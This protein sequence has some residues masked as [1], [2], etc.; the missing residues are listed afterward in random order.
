MEITSTTNELEDVIEGVKLRLV[1][2]SEKPV[3]ITIRGDTEKALENA[4]KFTEEFNKFAALVNELT[5]YD[6]ENNVAG[7]LLSNR[8]IDDIRRT[9]TTHLV[10]PVPG[11]PARLNMM[12]TLGVRLDDKGNLK[13][14]ENQLRSKVNDDFG[15]VADLFRNRGVSGNSAVDVVGIADDTQPNPDGY[16]VEITQLASQGSYSSPPLRAP[17]VISEL[18]NRLVVKVDG[19]QSQQ[20]TLQPG[21]YGI[22]EYA[23]ALQNQ[24]TNDPVV[25]NRR[26]R[27]IHDGE[28]VRVISGTFGSS[29]SIAFSP[30]VA[31]QP[32]AVGLTEGAQTSGQDVGG[33]IDGE[34]AE[35][36]GQVLRGADNSER[37]KGLRLFVTLS[38]N[39]LSPSAPEA[40]IK[41][42]KGV[43]ARMSTYLGRVVDPLRGEMKRITDGLRGR[44]RGYDQQLTDI[45]GR[46]DRKRGELQNRFTRLETQLSTLRSQ[47]QYMAS[48]FAS[49]PGAGGV[50][51][52]LPQG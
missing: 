12:F 48:Q 30:V 50:L 47:Q 16:P 25:G 7:P 15:A 2:T 23:A 29:S 31:E 41:V 9:L 21:A 17:I 3:T 43:A 36:L 20:I 38:E 19:K 5:K 10:N 32:A 46:I 45:N 6:Q 4:V 18:N 8:D 52:G 51:P 26:V 28:R 35:G 27:V 13:V 49:L 39:Q 11:L 14:D 37:V 24:I 33:T 40:V 1:S 44:I 34:R 22:D 42:T